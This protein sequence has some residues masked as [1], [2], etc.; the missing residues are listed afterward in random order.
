M[1]EEP[2]QMILH[3]Y[4]A[5]PYLFCKTEP[6][7]SDIAATYGELLRMLDEEP[8][9]SEACLR[10]GYDRTEDGIRFSVCQTGRAN[11]P[12]ETMRQAVSE[13]T[14]QPTPTAEKIAFAISANDYRFTQLPWTP[15]APS[16]VMTL[17]PFFAAPAEAQDNKGTFF[18]RMIKENVL[19]VVIQLLT[20]LA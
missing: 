20:P 10:C 19:E 11:P 7:V 6:A 3:L 13:G 18:L 17:L 16:L 2:R 8:V 12:D 5:I 9:G 4:Q 1:Q 14:L 15:E